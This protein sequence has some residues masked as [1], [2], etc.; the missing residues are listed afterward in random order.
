VHD[1]T[2]HPIFSKHKIPPEGAK[3]DALSL[4]IGRWALL[5]QNMVNIE[6]LAIIFPVQHI[7]KHNGVRPL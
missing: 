6:I 1:V 2:L 3:S 7:S 4:P 5:F